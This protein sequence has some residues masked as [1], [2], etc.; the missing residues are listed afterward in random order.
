MAAKHKADTTNE[1]PVLATCNCTLS[2]TFHD[3]IQQDE[4]NMTFFF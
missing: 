2:M 4:G 3:S 1:K